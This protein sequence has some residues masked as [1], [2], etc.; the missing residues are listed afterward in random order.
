[1]P[2]IEG[3]VIH[4][5]WEFMQRDAK[6]IY[7]GWANMNLV[8]GHMIN[9][10]NNKAEFGEV[11]TVT[12][13]TKSGQNQLHGRLFEQNTTSALN[14]RPFFAASTGQNIIN[15]FGASI[16]GLVIIGAGALVYEVTRRRSAAV[17]PQA[18]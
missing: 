2:D 10:V 6:V 13:I 8:E 12:A 3:A 9:L 14:A 15:D 4:A 11:T 5:T 16:G 17:A 7:L 1:M 18:A